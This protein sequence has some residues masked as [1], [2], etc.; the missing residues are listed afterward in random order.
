MSIIVAQ[1]AGFC[2]GVKRAVDTLEKEASVSPISTLGPI[3]HNDDVVARL[4][5]MGV[6]SVDDMSELVSV[7][8]GSDVTEEDAEALVAELSDA[9]PDVDVELNYGGQPIYYYMISIE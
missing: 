4:K 1:S 5:G 2:F 3:I 9:H 6:E 8:F 7:Y